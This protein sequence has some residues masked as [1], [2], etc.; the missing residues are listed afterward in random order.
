MS[1]LL[2]VFHFCLGGCPHRHT[3]RERRALH[4]IQVLHWVCEE[5]GHAVPAMDR[6]EQEHLRVVNDG[7]IKPAKVQRIAG[8][9]V[10]IGTRPSRRRSA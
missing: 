8:D 4:G 2:R 3:F 6:T 5:C 10:D 1:L 7:A 9:V